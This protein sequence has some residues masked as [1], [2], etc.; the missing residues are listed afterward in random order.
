MP[1]KEIK[2]VIIVLLCVMITFFVLFLH[3]GDALFR[4][5]KTKENLNYSNINNIKVLHVNDD[6]GSIQVEN[7]EDI[8]KILNYLNSL[9]LIKEKRPDYNINSMSELSDIGY[10]S[11][12]FSGS[13]FDAITFTTE[14]LTIHHNGHDWDYTSYYIKDSGYNPEDKTSNFYNFLS[15]L[16]SE[17]VEE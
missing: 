10:F 13:S 4:T 5:F 17:Y 8:E 7:K 14:Y 15:E 1:R 6:I 11:I 3:Y 9:D 16:V 2:F 12:Y